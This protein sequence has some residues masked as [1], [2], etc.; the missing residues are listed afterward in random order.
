MDRR[1]PLHFPG[2]FA[3]SRAGWKPRLSIREAVVKTVDYLT[4]NSELLEAVA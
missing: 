2:L 4:A 1:Q 3:D